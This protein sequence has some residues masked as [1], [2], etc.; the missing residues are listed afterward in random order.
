MDQVALAPDCASRRSPVHA[1]LIGKGIRQ[2][3]GHQPDDSRPQL[4]GPA[5]LLRAGL[6]LF[7]KV[8]C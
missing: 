8:E 4:E 5:V 3:A 2:L 1:V 6:R 7:L